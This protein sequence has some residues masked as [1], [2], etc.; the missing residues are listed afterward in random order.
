MTVSGGYNYVN[1]VTT[2][3]LYNTGVGYVVVSQCHPQVPRGMT[4]G[5]FLP[6]GGWGRVWDA[7]PIIFLNFVHYLA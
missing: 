4:D 6:R 1:Y 5:E 2:N 7:P 3:K